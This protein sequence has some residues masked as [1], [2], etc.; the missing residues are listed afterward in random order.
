M[1]M[2]DVITI[3]LIAISVGLVLYFVISGWALIIIFAGAVA[4]F[5]AR[6]FP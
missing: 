3:G 6:I 1:S 5:I 4:I 2:K